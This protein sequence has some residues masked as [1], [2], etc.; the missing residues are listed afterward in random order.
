MVSPQ[1][2]IRIEVHGEI[3]NLPS[4]AATAL[5]LVVNELAQNALEHAFVGRTEGQIE[6][7]LGTSP[8]QI[9]V[10]VKDN[11]IGLP[12]ELAHGLGW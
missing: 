12:P 7:S 10:L 2:D 6:I 9:I 4:K 8:D 11:G 1:Q 5:T 3:I